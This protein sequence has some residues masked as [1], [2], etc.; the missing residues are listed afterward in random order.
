MEIIDYI[1]FMNNK[2]KT[3]IIAWGFILIKYI[4]IIFL[5]RAVLES[6]SIILIFGGLLFLGIIAYDSYQFEKTKEK[7]T[8]LQLD[9]YRITKIK[10]IEKFFKENSIIRSAIYEGRIIEFNIFKT[11]TGGDWNEFK[12]SE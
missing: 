9:I 10:N 2:I 12:K 7:L 4:G 6:S 5:G 3:K 1:Y 8:D 11:L